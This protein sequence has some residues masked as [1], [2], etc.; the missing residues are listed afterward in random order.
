M[1]PG[2]KEA[3]FNKNQ[4]NDVRI[5]EPEGSPRQLQ[6]TTVAVLCPLVIYNVNNPGLLVKSYR[7]FLPYCRIIVKMVDWLRNLEGQITIYKNQVSEYR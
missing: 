5:E 3:V 6:I 4:E 2:V 7:Y 1:S